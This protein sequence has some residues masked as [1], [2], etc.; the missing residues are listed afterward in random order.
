MNDRSRDRPTPRGGT[1]GVSGTPFAVDVTGDRQ[2]RDIWIVLL[3][4]P[5]IWLAHF[6]VVYLA[7]EAGCTG[8][9]PGLELFD[10]PVPTVLT[11]VA[12]AVGCIACLGFA[13]WGYRRWAGAR[14]SGAGEGD[15]GGRG[16]LAFVGLLLS[17]FS[18]LSILFVGLPAAFL[19]PC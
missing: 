18:F 7:A 2:S 11:L 13:G 15:E 10:P 5:V 12:T 16:P 14:R 19:A 8:D 6:L 17:L 3:A 4:G 9:G 1:T